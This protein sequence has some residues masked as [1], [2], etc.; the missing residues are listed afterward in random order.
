MR[1]MR[2]RRRTDLEHIVQLVQLRVHLLHRLAAQR[3][4]LD[5]NRCND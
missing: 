5:K 4:F 1:R 2:R 3:E